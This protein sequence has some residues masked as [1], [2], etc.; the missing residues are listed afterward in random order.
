M[1]NT[2]LRLLL[3][4]CLLSLA[5]PALAATAATTSTQLSPQDEA[6]AVQGDLGFGYAISSGGASLGIDTSAVFIPDTATLVVDPGDTAAVQSQLSATDNGNGTWTL[7]DPET[8]VAVTAKVQ[9]ATSTY[10]SD[11]TAHP[12]S[13]TLPVVS[14]AAVSIAPVLWNRV[15]RLRR[16]YAC[17]VQAFC[18][19]GCFFGY[20]YVALKK[21]LVCSYTGRPVDLCLDSLQAV[22]KL[23][24][25]TC[26]DCT[27]PILGSWL[28]YRYV[29]ATF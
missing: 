22:C 8:G 7:P 24:R 3:G 4:L 27:G 12:V 1:K 20:G 15:W 21:F 11:A 16:G 14:S 2:L 17:G 13:S 5:V 18:P 6:T 19:G 23:N 10:A 28:N 29:C 26:R 9:Y 25:Y